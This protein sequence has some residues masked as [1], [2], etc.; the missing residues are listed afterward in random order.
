[1][2][3]ASKAEARAAAPVSRNPETLRRFS[4]AWA[5]GDVD[6]LMSLMTDDPIYRS[7]AG[8]G[9]GGEYRGREEVRAAFTRMLSGAPAPGATPPP[10]PAGEVAFFD[11]RALS[12]WTLPGRA[13]DGSP[14]TIRGVDV[15]TFDAEGRIAIKDAY[16]K[17]W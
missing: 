1:M 7:S 6:T 14:A 12:Y 4:E 15:I 9:P 13:P 8:P 5:K 16:R 11:D 10:P 17:S 3:H 2:S